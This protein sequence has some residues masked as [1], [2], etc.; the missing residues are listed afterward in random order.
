MS[1]ISNSQERDGPVIFEKDTG[2]PATGAGPDPFKEVDDFLSKVDGG[3]DEG[4]GRGSKRYGMQDG[5]GSSRKRARVD[6]EGD[7]RR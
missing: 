1:N 6:V 7:D 3:D 2:G 4:K 5:G